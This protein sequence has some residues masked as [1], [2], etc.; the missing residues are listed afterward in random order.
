MARHVEGE[1]TTIKNLPEIHRIAASYLDCLRNNSAEYDEFM[2]ERLS[3]YYLL[4]DF[5]QT[6]GCRGVIQTALE[7]YGR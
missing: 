6:L 4:L 1:R 2:A 3:V 7:W 5:A